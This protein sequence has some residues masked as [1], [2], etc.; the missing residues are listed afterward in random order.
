MSVW[1]VPFELQNI[2]LPNLVWWWSII[3]RSVMQKNLFAIFK[4]K[5]TVRAHRIKIWL[6]LLVDLLNCWTA[7]SLATKSGLMV[8][9][10]V[11][12]CVWWGELLS[13]SRLPQKFKILMNVC[14]DNIFWTAEPFTTEVGMMI[15]HHKP[16]CFSK[17]L[18]C[19]LQDQGHGHSEWSYNK[20]MTFL[21]IFWTADPFTTTLCLMAQ[22][23]KVDCLVKDWI[24]QLRSRSR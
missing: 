1:M 15:H 14:P 24:A 8:H 16:E 13:R 22:H 2:L 17:R 4:V 10:H 18:V 6:F 12:V 9:H 7:D 23:D 11:C 3:S 21:Y 5:V 19:C 20:N